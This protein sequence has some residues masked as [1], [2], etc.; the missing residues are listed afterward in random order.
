MI[1]IPSGNVTFLF[2]DIEGSIMLTLENQ[3]DLKGSLKKYYSIIEQSV[4]SNNGFIFKTIG[5]AFCCSFDCETDA[6]NASFDFQKSI[7][8]E[9]WNGTT[10]K[11]RMGIHS[12][13]AE[14]KGNDYSGYITLATVNRVVSAA[15]GGQLLISKDAFKIDE[16][17]LRKGISFRDLGER[18]LKDLKEPMRLFQMVSDELTS[19]FPPLK[20]LDA[21]PNNLPVQLTN[22]IGREKE[23]SEIKDLL[24]TSR[25][26][27][28]LGP[29]GTGK[30]RLSVQ[31]GAD[32]IDEFVNGV[33]FI[34]FASLIDPTLIL[35]ETA[36]ALKLKEDS[37]RNI[38]EVLID[39]LK[40]KELLLIFDNCEHLII[41]CA[42]LF[43]NLLTSCPKL[44][45]IASSRESLRIS[46]EKVFHVP[47][48]SIPDKLEF[49]TVDSVRG[50]EAVQ[51]FID[52]ASSMRHDFKITNENASAI[53]QLCHH[54]DGIPLAIELAA[55]RIKVMTVEKIL[56]N[57]SNR[58][59]LLTDG[60]RTA[61][62]R[63]QTLRALIDWSY[64]LLSEKEKT[65]FRRLSVFS[66]GW[67]LEAAEEICCDDEIMEY[68]I[69]DLISDLTDK[70]IIIS[71]EI[72]R[73][74]RFSMLETIRQYCLEKSDS[75]E[76]VYKKHFQYFLKLSGSDDSTK[77]YQHDLEWKK[78]MEPEQDNLRYAIKL[79]L[80]N[81]TEQSA[82]LVKNVADF[83][84]ITGN[85]T[86]SYET[87]KKLLELDMEINP[88]LKAD[89]TL[90][91][92][93]LS[94][95]LDETDQA[96]RYIQSALEYYKSSGNK[97][98]TAECLSV[99]GM[100]SFT[101]GETEFAVKLSEE[102]LD[103]LRDQNKKNLEANIKGN[104]A[105]YCSAKGDSEYALKLLEDSILTY[106][107]L[108][109]K[110]M[111]SKF[112]VSKGGIFYQSGDLEKA[113][114]CFE[115][116]LLLLEEMNDQFS[117]TTTLYNMGNLNF[118]LKKYSDATGFY[119]AAKARAKEYGLIN[120]YDRSFI[121]EG[122]IALIR[123]ENEK[124][125]EIFISCLQSFGKNSEKLK[126]IL[127]IYGLGSYFYY[128]KNYAK[129]AKLFL[130]AERMNEDFKF[131]FSGSRLDE[132]KLI[133]SD[134]KEKLTD[135]EFDRLKILINDLNLDNAT[136]TVLLVSNE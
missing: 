59:R 119:E 79:S 71:K 85:Y 22:F 65:L 54:L 10:F 90:N 16:E 129:S 135:I 89:L 120:I 92:A 57:I 15:N 126:L 102:A 1:N 107:E 136:Q 41:E 20:T 124:A 105:T 52:R 109:D 131:R 62:P 100:I 7:L 21:R 83:W 99:Y 43:Q 3:N 64:D 61:L 73:V 117:Y 45:I 96:D 32:V 67:S 123:K 37:G 128:E 94:S 121:K 125:K 58:F 11:V 51:L 68:E 118:Q 46:G 86:E 31:A 42:K 39:Y 69:I 72:N 19:D 13:K 18:R 101:K 2:T 23:L 112:L 33:W 93:F 24:K 78:I 80:I 60:N 26:I 108:N 38:A 122:E 130:L 111:L 35:N 76:E 55:A 34:E 110:N 28:L 116:G 103:L 47:V 6:V 95:Q 49:H 36:S 53:V 75:N 132:N 134:L 40:G 27:T 106:R 98:R 113:M 12:G 17:K 127:C 30:T 91:A 104:L 84:E 87:L 14:W 70:S 66:G 29:G 63:Q 82:E 9:E 4:S 133:V 88:S 74:T 5:D 44:K 8:N 56:E 25:L 81:N 115:E 97:I 114:N 50:F 77:E 48:L